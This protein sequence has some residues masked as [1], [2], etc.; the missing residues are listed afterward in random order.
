MST[1][2]NGRK[3]I[4]TH[5]SHTGCRPMQAQPS[6]MAIQN[7]RSVRSNGRPSLVPVVDGDHDQTATAPQRRPRRTWPSVVSSDTQSCARATRAAPQRRRRRAASGSTDASPRSQVGHAV[8][9]VRVTRRRRARRR[10]S[11]SKRAGQSSAAASS[12]VACSLTS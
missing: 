5:S 1:A 4:T 11:A 12:G 10:R 9:R 8:A 3:S 7:S 2:A 6:P